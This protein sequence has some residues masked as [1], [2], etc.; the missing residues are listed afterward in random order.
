M[1]TGREV[2][3]KNKNEKKLGAE[4]KTHEKHGKRTHEIRYKVLRNANLA[5]LGPSSTVTSHQLP[6]HVFLPALI[7]V[8]MV[9]DQ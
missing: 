7:Y 9:R 6:K 4:T 8:T 1:S 3:A 5:F 2:S